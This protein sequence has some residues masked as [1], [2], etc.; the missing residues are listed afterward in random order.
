MRCPECEVFLCLTLGRNCW[1]E[2]HS[3][4]LDAAKLRS[5]SGGAA[6][7]NTKAG[8]RMLQRQPCRHTLTIV[9]GN[10]RGYCAVCNKKRAQVGNKVKHRMKGKSLTSVQRLPVAKQLVRTR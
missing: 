5:G 8:Q 2:W 3:T 6:A 9:D 1:H 10:S 7:G 4:P